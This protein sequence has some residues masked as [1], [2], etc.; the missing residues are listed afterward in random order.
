MYTLPLPMEKQNFG[1]SQWWRLQTTVDYQNENLKSLR[2][3]LKTMQKKS[4]KPGKDISVAEIQNISRQGIWIFVEDQE[5]FL[6]F[7]LYPWFQKA[8]IE[9]IYDFQLQHKKQ[10][11]WKALDIDI[12]ID[13]LKHPDAYPLIYK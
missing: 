2:G 4:K 12:D 10:L 5:F 3:L 6:P 13:S 11:H 7:D 1:L 9:Q 8:T